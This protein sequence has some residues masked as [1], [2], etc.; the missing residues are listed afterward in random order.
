MKGTTALAVTD[1]ILASVTGN[2]LAQLDANNG[3]QAQTDQGARQ[4]LLLAMLL[5]ASQGVARWSPAAAPA[6][7]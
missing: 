6:A 4:A 2:A 5:N 3:A 1:A 7:L